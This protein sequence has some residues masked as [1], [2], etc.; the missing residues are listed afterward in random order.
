MVKILNSTFFHLFLKNRIKKYCLYF[1]HEIVFPRDS[2][3][4]LP[5]KASNKSLGDD[6]RITTDIFYNLEHHVSFEL[7]LGSWK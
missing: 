2:D 5:K 4:R 7:N 6:A 1:Y 3:F